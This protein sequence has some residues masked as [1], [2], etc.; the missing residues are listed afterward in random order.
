[1]APDGLAAHWLFDG[2]PA[3]LLEPVI[4]ASRQLRFLSG[5]TIF[6]EGQPADGLFLITA[7]QARVTGTGPGGDP[8]LLTLVSRNGILGE[9]AVL[10]GQPRSGT[11]TA[12]GL[13]IGHY[14]PGEVFLDLLEQSPSVCM[15][16][17]VLLT[18]RLR[19]TDRRL[20][21]LPSRG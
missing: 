11:A 18:K 6:R 13:C 16:V 20:S 4:A 8:V 10:D 1:M 17:L 19:F 7:G 9:M 14:V 3:D 21:E 2:I 5:D 15:R 12:V